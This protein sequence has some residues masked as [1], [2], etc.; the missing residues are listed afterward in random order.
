[1]GEKV[2]IFTDNEGGNITII[3]PG[4]TPWQFDALSENLR[5]F[6]DKDGWQCFNFGLDGSFSSTKGSFLTNTMNVAMLDQSGTFQ[7]RMWMG[8]SASLWTDN[9]GGNLILK[10]P[11]GNHWHFDAF[12]DTALRIYYGSPNSEVH[13]MW[14]LDASTGIFSGGVNWSK[15]AD[16]SSVIRNLGEKFY[17]TYS[18]PWG[19]TAGEHWYG[20]ECEGGCSMAILKDNPSAGKLSIKIDGVVYQNEGAGKVL[21]TTNFIVNGTTLTINF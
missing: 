19:N 18:S 21:D 3:G 2:D 4:G 11:N 12:T 1:M 17:S 6:S 15:I 5:L 16:V 7:Q 13:T 8:D 20:V 10:S 14:S 9:E